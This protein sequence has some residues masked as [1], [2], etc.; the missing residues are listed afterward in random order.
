MNWI[1]WMVSYNS[2]FIQNPLTPMKF[3]IPKEVQPFYPNNQKEIGESIWQIFNIGKHM[4]WIKIPL[5]FSARILRYYG[6]REELLLCALSVSRERMGKCWL[7]IW[8]LLLQLNNILLTL[9]I[10]G[11]RRYKSSTCVCTSSTIRRVVA[12]SLIL[13]LSN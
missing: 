8:R 10:M 9:F 11:R 3:D 7:L 4:S 1:M 6:C 2:Y 13:S 5:Y 12:A